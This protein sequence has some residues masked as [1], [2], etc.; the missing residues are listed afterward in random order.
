M[1][2]QDARRLGVSK[3]FKA[4]IVAVIILF[5]ILLLVTTQGDFAN[6]IIFFWAA[7]FN[8]FILGALGIMLG[9]TYL[10]AGIAGRQI[11]IKK[12]LFWIPAIIYP[13]LI[14]IAIYVYTFLWIHISGN[15]SSQ[16]FQQSFMQHFVSPLVK[17]GSLILIPLL[18]IWFWATSLMRK[19]NIKND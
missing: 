16:S 5:V 18:A 4:T 15:A 13:C 17:V 12:Q 19:V 7:T 10:F 11:I 1:T 2:V 8:S 14:V 3:I 9:M 6:N